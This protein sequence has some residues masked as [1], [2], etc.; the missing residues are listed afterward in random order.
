LQLQPFSSSVFSAS[1]PELRVIR[2]N[3]YPH[4]RSIEKN[5]AY[6][7]VVC[8]CV[9]AFKKSKFVSFRRRLV[10][11]D[12]DEKK[13]RALTEYTMINTNSE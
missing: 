1:K 3:P 12:D 4:L 6:Q 2:L 11:D 8:V 10:D 5:G 13:T 7:P 9:C